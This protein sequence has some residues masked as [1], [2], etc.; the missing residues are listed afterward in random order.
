MGHQLNPI[1]HLYRKQLCLK[2]LINKKHRSQTSQTRRGWINL[3]EPAPSLSVCVCVCVCACVRACACIADWAEVK[4]RWYWLEPTDGWLGGWG[5]FSVRTLWC[6]SVRMSVFSSTRTWEET[7]HSMY[8]QYACVHVWEIDLSFLMI[9]GDAGVTRHTN[10][11]PTSSSSW[12]TPLATQWYDHFD[13]ATI[14]SLW[15]HSGMYHWAG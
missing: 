7:A 5:W 3:Q 11:H 9:D 14:C 12:N 13:I 10:K 2:I 8:A 15:M 4:G 1:Y 6:I